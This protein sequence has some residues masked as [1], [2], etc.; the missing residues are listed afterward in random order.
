M[1]NVLMILYNDFRC[2]SA[3]HTHNLAN[4]LS[5]LGFDC[6]V[7]VPENKASVAVLSEHQYRPIEFV[8]CDY[9]EQLFANGRG[10]DIIHA[11]TPREI[12]RRCWKDIHRR[13]GGRL[14]VHLED[15]EEFLAERCL[16]KS[17]DEIE[18]MGLERFPQELA[19]PRMYREFLSQAEGVTVIIDQLKEFIPEGVPTITL[20]PGV[21]T[22]L[23]YQRDRDLDY[24]RSIAIPMNAT[25]LTYTGNVHAANASEVRSLYLAVAILNREGH[26]TALVRAG[27][28]SYAFLGENDVLGA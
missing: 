5:S 15:N 12:V 26:P 4:C 19:H 8:E 25:V 3:V 2:N 22:S 10:P 13:Y 7:A 9:L 27:L 21:E 28:D 14:F 23:F 16:N 1:K 18:Q 17:I 11:W 24:A 6:I 20:W